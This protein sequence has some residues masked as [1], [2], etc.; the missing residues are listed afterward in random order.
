MT[1]ERP[2]R[3]VKQPIELILQS[4]PDIQPG[5]A[6]A[7]FAAT[8]YSQGS[9][10]FETG[11]PPD[12]G[13]GS[14]ANGEDGI[15][16]GPAEFAAEA[17]R[18]ALVR[19]CLTQ[20]VTFIETERAMADIGNSY[21]DVTAADLA[22]ATLNIDAARLI[23]DDQRR[24]VALGHIARK[25]DDRMLMAEVVADTRRIFAG[26]PNVEPLIQVAAASRDMTMLDEIPD[27]SAKEEA[28]YR[29]AVH[30]KDPA[31]I[32]SLPN[33]DLRARVLAQIVAYTDSDFTPYLEMMADDD[34]RQ[35]ALASRAYLKNNIALAGQISDI[36]TRIN[37][38]LAIAKAHSDTADQLPANLPDMIR[39][40]D[41]DALKV[42]VYCNE[43]ITITGDTSLVGL[44]ERSARQIENIADRSYL[45]S[46]V[47]A[48]SR[49]PELFDEVIAGYEANRDKYSSILRDDIHAN[50]ASGSGDI[51]YARQM[52]DN[53]RR[54][55]TLREVIVRDRNI[56]G[57]REINDAQIFED[58]VLQYD[59]ADLVLSMIERDNG[60]IHA[61]G[62]KVIVKLCLQMQTMAPILRIGKAWQRNEALIA[63]VTEADDATT[64]RSIEDEVTRDQALVS[65]AERRGDLELA[66]SLRGS[67]YVGKRA[68]RLV[69]D[70]ESAMFD[71]G[72]ID[73][74]LSIAEIE[75]IDAAG[76]RE[77]HYYRRLREGDLQVV[78]LIAECI[79]QMPKKYRARQYISLA[80]T[81][82]NPEYAYHA[83][84]ELKDRITDRTQL[85]A[86]SYAIM[87]TI[88]PNP[89]N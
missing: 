78:P 9:E 47:Y 25:T 10:G 50:L 27:A 29:I 63:Y 58:L 7:A 11:G 45:L 13:R 22:V 59:D 51:V 32:D 1:N 71:S 4:P 84:A 2:A 80:E 56:D 75:M 44:L 82:H 70:I 19:D 52:T 67:E 66:Q 85:E 23:T 86:V 68:T 42:A 14:T 73:Q 76:D 49:S 74:T 57:A 28:Q 8:A 6:V 55:R 35:P 81:A 30:L 88:N 20:A 46:K 61:C 79:E 24:F 41:A 69:S 21:F 37:T 54:Y 12:D 5:P 65:I 36:S 39:Q 38:M 40:L 17:E 18:T 87:L 60:Y 26:K 33:A 15:S 16:Y 43:Y 62:L 48:V 53:V 89:N 72:R 77:V 34:E 31:F 64:A 3:T 83:L